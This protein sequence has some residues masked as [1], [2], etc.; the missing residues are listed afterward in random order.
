MYNGFHGAPLDTE[1][2]NV[3]MS[4]IEVDDGGERSY[5]QGLFVN[6]TPK[7]ALQDSKIPVSTI[8]IEEA[9][10]KLLTPEDP[11]FRAFMGHLCEDNQPK[12]VIRKCNEGSAY[13]PHAVAPTGAGQKI[14]REHT[15]QLLQDVGLVGPKHKPIIGDRALYIQRK[16]AREYAS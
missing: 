12:V 4:P 5:F 15:K 10:H 7:Q 11:R 14:S 6:T 13:Y 8:E 2:G 3:W 9:G 1:D 16:Y